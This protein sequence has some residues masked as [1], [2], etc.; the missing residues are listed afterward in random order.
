MQRRMTALLLPFTPPNA[1]DTIMYSLERDD[2]FVCSLACN[3]SSFWDHCDNAV[4]GRRSWSW[5]NWSVN[6][7]Q[8][9]TK[10]MPCYTN[11]K[12]GDSRALFS[13]DLVS[14]WCHISS[15]LGVTIT[16]KVFLICANSYLD[17]S[18]GN[19]EI[20]HQCVQWT[21]MRLSNMSS[22]YSRS[23]SSVCRDSRSANELSAYEFSTYGTRHGG[24]I[25]ASI[26]L[27]T[28][29]I[30]MFFLQVFTHYQ[31]FIHSEGLFSDGR[32]LYLW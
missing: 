15:I 32:L 9:S 5:N 7:L 17:I 10:K 30:L 13:L 6:G 18:W 24:L 25:L 14:F 21:W 3:R 1:F 27:N 23:M 28:I 12:C 22:S 11:K 31:S 2:G 8:Q 29:S 16:K 20:R 4:I 26:H 19:H